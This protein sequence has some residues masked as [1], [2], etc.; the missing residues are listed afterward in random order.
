MANLPQK[1]IAKI[2]GGKLSLQARKLI[3]DY[4]AGQE[5]KTVIIEMKR[6]HKKRSISQNAFY[7]AVI[8]PFVQEIFAESGETLDAEEVHSF[9]KEHVG[10]LVRVIIQPDGAR[11]RVVK[12]SKDLTTAEWEQYISLIAAWCGS[13]GFILPSPNEHLNPPIL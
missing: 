7:W 12:S 13:I 8:V 6:Y 10:K 3:T 11:V 2:L 4:L 5:G 9:L 1:V